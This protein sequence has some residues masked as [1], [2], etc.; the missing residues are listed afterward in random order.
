M[1]TVLKRINISLPENLYE[2]LRIVA[3]KEYK[4]ISGIIR[5]S[6]LEK[7]EEDFTAEELALISQASEAFHKGEGINWKD[8]KRE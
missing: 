3:Q 5:E 8:I 4:S 7:V 1:K 6:V 2:K